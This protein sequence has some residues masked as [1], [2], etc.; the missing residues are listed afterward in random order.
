V[1][2]GG[3]LPGMPLGIQAIRLIS[4]A[5]EAY[6]CVAGA[7][8]GG[9]LAEPAPQYRPRHPE[10]SALYQQFEAHVDSYVR[11][12]EERFEPHSGPLRPEVVSGCRKNAPP[13]RAG[14]R[15]GR[16]W[17]GSLAR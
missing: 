4:Y 15:T 2:A 5:D 6:V 16:D 3:L 11:A 17:T 1:A 14:N 12:Y 8:S 13:A 9:I 7:Y 10:S